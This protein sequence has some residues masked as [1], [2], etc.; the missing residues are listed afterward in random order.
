MLALLKMECAESLHQPAEVGLEGMMSEENR[1]T[2][3]FLWPFVAIWR[4]VAWIV[5]LTGRLVAVILGA[6]FMIVGA[7]VS[8]TII[9]AVIGIPLGILGFMMVLRGLF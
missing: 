6:V 9:G 1:R 3:W 5:E 7:I 4:L 8:V 2:P